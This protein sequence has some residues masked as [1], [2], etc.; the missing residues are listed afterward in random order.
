MADPG[1][2]HADLVVARGIPA[3]SGLGSGVAVPGC[4]SRALVSPGSGS[5]GGMTAAVTT[6][7]MACICS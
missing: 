2:G 5:R 1:A 6:M 3:R 7:A 4:G